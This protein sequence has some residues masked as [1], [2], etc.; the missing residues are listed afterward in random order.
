MSERRDRRRL[1]ARARALG[2]SVERVPRRGTPEGR[3][4]RPF[5]V[6]LTGP[7]TP[8]ARDTP[9]WPRTEAPDRYEPAEALV[10]ARPRTASCC[11]VVLTREVM[12]G[13]TVVML[14]SHTALCPVWSVPR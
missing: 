5:A 6:P 1:H 11:E 8:P 12:D 10:A 3:R 13:G 9:Y 2:V 7:V 14:S 4:A